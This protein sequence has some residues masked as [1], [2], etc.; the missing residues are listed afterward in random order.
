MGVHVGASHLS[1][2]A[3]MHLSLLACMDAVPTI[4]ETHTHVLPCVA[5]VFGALAV[6]DSWGRRPLLIGGSIGC[7][8]ALAAAVGAAAARSVPALLLCLCAFTLSF[9]FSWAGGYWV[10]VSEIFSMGAKSPATSAAA[11]LLFLTGSVTNLVFLSLVE[12]L[13][14]YAFLLFAAV[15][16]SG[17]V[18]VHQALPET[19]GRTLVAIQAMMSGGGAAGGV[20]SVG[21]D[22]PGGAGVPGGSMQLAAVHS[23]MWH[24]RSGPGTGE[25]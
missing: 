2:H 7:G 25:L 18:Y 14:P 23:D 19:K 11:A 22:A 5:G 12:G 21:A 16:F 24:R 4:R 1:L 13:G 6:V 3:C 10:V 8:A 9:S 20:G 15:A 17:A